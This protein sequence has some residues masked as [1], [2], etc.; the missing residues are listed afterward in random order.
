MTRQC[1]ADIAR[2]SRC[3]DDNEERREHR[4][5]LKLCV[6]LVERQPPWP[7]LCPA[8]GIDSAE[9][10]RRNFNAVASSP[11]RGIKSCV[12]PTDQLIER[13][14]CLSGFKAGYSEAR[15]G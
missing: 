13:R 7:F 3:C 14:L 10:R 6:A 5:N 4:I 15:C 8:S 2:S 12:R 11:F 9:Y 1:G